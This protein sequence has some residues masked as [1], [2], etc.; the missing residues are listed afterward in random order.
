MSLEKGFYKKSP[1]NKKPGEF[2]LKTTHT[3]FTIFIFKI[4]LKIRSLISIK[5]AKFCL[6]CYFFCYSLVFGCLYLLAGKKNYYQ[7]AV[8]ITD[9]K[10]LLL[11]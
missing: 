9:F 1:G 8:K 7:R 3:F 6:F 4:Y 5:N 10:L 2:C 11:L